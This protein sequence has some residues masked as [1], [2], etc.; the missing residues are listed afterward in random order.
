MK[1]DF[2]PREVMG[3][4]PRSPQEKNH[5]KNEHNGF[6]AGDVKTRASPE[7]YKAEK[8]HAHKG[9]DVGAAKA[10][11][12]AAHRFHGKSRR[13]RGLRKAKTAGG[14]IKTAIIGKR[15]RRH[16]A[17]VPRLF[18]KNGGGRS[19]GENPCGKAMPNRRQSD[20]RGR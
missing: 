3:A 16:R 15:H 1:N 11:G 12:H 6:D 13:Q 14:F 19:K 18:C 8:L 17:F 2:F 9:I 20:S 10:C 4:A 7:R 5:P